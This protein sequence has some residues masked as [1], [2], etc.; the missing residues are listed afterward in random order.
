MRFMLI[1]LTAFVVG[2]AV[3]A[4]Q[5]GDRPPS[6][7]VCSIKVSGM[8]CGECAKT[9]E[10]AAK[11]IDGVKAAKVSQQKG[12][13][14]ITYDPVKTNPD[15]IAKVLTDKTPFRAEAQRRGNQQ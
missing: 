2:L 15:A 10:K 3:S 13:A 5:N 12:A 14:E 11:K 4:E 6:S 7:Q 8:F 1:A 9:V